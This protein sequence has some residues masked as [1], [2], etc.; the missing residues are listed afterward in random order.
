MVN[1]ETFILTDDDGRSGILAHGK[2]HLSG[3]DGVFDQ[4][5]GLFADDPVNMG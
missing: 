1:P 4:L 5:F 2:F 3:D